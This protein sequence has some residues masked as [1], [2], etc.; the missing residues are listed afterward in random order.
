MSVTEK[1][2]KLPGVVLHLQSSKRHEVAGKQKVL[3]TV[4]GTIDNE[5]VW[6][7]VE[8][9]FINGFRVYTQEDFKGELINVFRTELEQLEGCVRALTHENEKMQREN[10]LLREENEDLAKKREALDGF[11]RQ[12][13]G[14]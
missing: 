3:L 12:L 10:T 14:Y 2:Q 9:M 7:A 13:R 5:V 1:E 8:K 6:S 11:A 4:D